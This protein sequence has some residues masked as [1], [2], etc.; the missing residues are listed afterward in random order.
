[1]NGSHA[2][3]ANG[4]GERES[5]ED[6]DESDFVQN[7]QRKAGS[8]GWGARSYAPIEVE[9]YQSPPMMYN[10]KLKL[11]VRSNH[12]AA[13]HLPLSERPPIFSSNLTASMGSLDGIYRR[14]SI[15]PPIKISGSDFTRVKES[16]IV[17]KI[18]CCQ[19]DGSSTLLFAV[20]IPSPR[21][22]SKSSI[23]FLSLDLDTV[24]ML[25]WVTRLQP[26]PIGPSKEN[27]SLSSS[28][29]PSS[30]TTLL[31]P[32]THH[33]LASSTNS[34][35]RDHYLKSLIGDDFVPNTKSLTWREAGHVPTPPEH[36]SS[37]YKASQFTDAQLLSASVVSKQH[38]I[39]DGRSMTR[40]PSTASDMSETTS[41]DPPRRHKRDKSQTKSQSTAIQGPNP[42][43]SSSPSTDV[44]TP[45]SASDGMPSPENQHSS[46]H[47]SGSHPANANGDS[48]NS[49]RT[50]FDSEA[51]T[52]TSQMTTG[53]N[54]E[55]SKQV[56]N[57]HLL[58]SA[59]GDQNGQNGDSS[60]SNSGSVTPAPSTPTSS[61]SSSYSTFLRDPSEG[62]EYMAK[63]MHITNIAS[64]A[65]CLALNHVTSSWN[66]FDT[67]AGFATGQILVYDPKSPRSTSEKE[68]PNSK[69]RIFNDHVKMIQGGVRK[70]AWFTHNQFMAT[71]SDGFIYMFHLQCED[72]PDFAREEIDP[73]RARLPKHKPGPG[74]NSKVSDKDSASG[75]NG[76]RQ[77]ANGVNG[78]KA[79]KPTILVDNVSIPADGWI[80][81]T[82]WL[83]VHRNVGKAY[84]PVNMWAISPGVPVTDFANSADLKWLAATSK[85]GILR[86]YS[87]ESYELEVAFK[88]YFGGFTCLAWS[89]DGAYIVTGGEDDLV[90]VWSVHEKTL[91]ARGAAH[92]SWVSKVAFDPHRCSAGS[93]Y[94]F[95]SVGQDGQ[96]AIWEFSADTLVPPKANLALHQRRRSSMSNKGPPLHSTHLAQAS[97]DSSR[98]PSLPP[99][100]IPPIPKDL[101]YQLEPIVVQ[102]ITTS[103]CSELQFIGAELLMIGGWAGQCAFFLL[104]TKGASPAF[105][106][107]DPSQGDANDIFA[108]QDSQSPAPDAS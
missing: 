37:N 35:A 30:G 103:P 45:P 3:V 12:E 53:N 59:I 105:I 77:T 28:H 31:S 23:R 73:R 21:K 97:I 11:K 7:S 9:W 104:E 60:T 33:S 27:F 51:A 56:P 41:A 68:V 71:Y 102:R 1:V 8:S 92:S 94:R 26:G 46:Q 62:A 82:T 79:G 80:T 43:Q 49:S 67:I 24:Q 86:I 58:L 93:Y 44:D 54:A 15:L 50:S 106:P 20:L 48:E 57:L 32:S 55:A 40:S 18:D 34:S 6:W 42:D 99:N 47:D 100:V 107:V 17:T 98:F 22:G 5:L 78:K 4:R 52:A 36:E 101:A 69:W 29:A 14:V 39:L 65:T 25:P 38:V 89:P 10:L 63:E 81:E 85:D 96:V 74:P 90:S 108:K 61:T 66:Q 76:A 88:S 83:R 91:A 19:F 95:A 72:D 13:R 87:M 75:K 84:N 16:S 2:S 70:L 64:E